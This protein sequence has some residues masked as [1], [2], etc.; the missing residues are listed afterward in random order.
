MWGKLKKEKV[1]MNTLEATK[2]KERENKRT[3]FYAAKS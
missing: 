2:K 1:K 3:A